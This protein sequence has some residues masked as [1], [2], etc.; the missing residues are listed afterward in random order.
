MQKLAN[1]VTMGF[2]LFHIIRLLESMK[3]L[4]PFEKGLVAHLVADWLL[5]NHWMANNK[6]D[7]RH[8]AAW[9]HALIQF[10]ALTIAL[11]WRVGFVLGILHLLIDTRV[12]LSWWRTFFKQTS[13]GPSAMHVA[14]WSDQVVHIAS[15]AGGIALEEYFE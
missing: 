11:G 13:D 14:I 1:G 10:V 6:M 5:Q 3:K 9:V 12:P 15:I 4:T 7:L 2:C 8:P